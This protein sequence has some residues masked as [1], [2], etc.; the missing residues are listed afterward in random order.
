MTI[1]EWVKDN[2][3][4]VT[5]TLI[6]REAA[7]QYLVDT[8]QAVDDARINRVVVEL[9]DLGLLLGAV[10]RPGTYSRLRKVTS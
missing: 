4:V 3:R 1:K 9:D 5:K 10:N 7:R 6:A 2:C 8:D